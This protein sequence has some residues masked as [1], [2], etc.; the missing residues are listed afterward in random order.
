MLRLKDI[1]EF[2]LIDRIKKGTI[3]KPETVLCGIGDD[4]AVLCLSDAYHLLASTDMLVEDVHFTLDTATPYEIGYKAMAVNISDIAA[5]A[6]IPEQALISIG[7]AGD[8]EVSF[9]DELYRGLKECART[10]GVNIVGGDTVSSPEGVVINVTI[11][12]KVEK[13]KAVLRSGA[14][15]GDYLLVTGDLGAAAAGLEVILK[16]LPVNKE[17]RDYL[18]RR[19]FQPQPRVIEARLAATTGAITAA[20]DISDGLAAE[21]REISKAAGVGAVIYAEKIPL[22]MPTVRAAAM[23]G[24]DPLDYALF[25]GEDFELLLA[26]RPEAVKKVQE[27][28]AGTCGIPVTV[29]GEVLP[30][31]KGLLIEQNGRVGEL[32]KGGYTHFQIE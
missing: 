4:A 10:F 5:M 22:A 21:L 18:R 16:G 6:G 25:G 32:K 31:E 14:R 2:E 12:G 17:D 26:C 13:G 24:K 29:I 3:I 1:G 8:L 27:A 19:H 23:A 15:P 7:L 28:V 9:V 11:L 30:P 20:D